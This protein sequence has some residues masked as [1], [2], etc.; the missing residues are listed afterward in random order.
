[1]EDNFIGDFGC[2]RTKKEIKYISH[3][4]RVLQ[5]N[6]KLF[7]KTQESVLKE[8][9]ESADRRIKILLYHFV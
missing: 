5:S 3:D 7:E 8:K 2:I 1:M 6:Y 4:T 9:E